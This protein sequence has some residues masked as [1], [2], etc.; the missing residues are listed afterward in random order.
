MGRNGRLV[1]INCRRCGALLCDVI[2]GA[3]VRCPACRVWTCATFN[4]D[5]Q[6][7]QDAQTG[8]SEIR[9]T[10]HE[11]R[12]KPGNRKCSKRMPEVRRFVSAFSIIWICL[13]F[14]ISNFV[15]SA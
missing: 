3:E 11:T 14:R 5:A 1:R 8:K 10:K 9:S 13:G 7:E 15:L 6:D 12:G 2:S 4:R